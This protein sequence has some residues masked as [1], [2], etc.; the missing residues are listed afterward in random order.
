MISV[1]KDFYLKMIELTRRLYLRLKVLFSVPNLLGHDQLD[2]KNYVNDKSIIAIKG[3]KYYSMAESGFDRLQNGLL[4]QYYAITERFSRGSNSVENAVKVPLKFGMWLIALFVIFFGGWMVLAKI[5]GAAVAPG[6]I[7]FATSKQN[8]QHQIGGTIKNILVKE[9]DLVRRGQILLTMQDVDLRSEYNSLNN[10]LFALRVNEERLNAEKNHSVDFVL[11]DDLVALM[12]E[13]KEFVDIFKSQ[14]RL[15][16]ANSELYKTDLQILDAKQEQFKQNVLGLEIQR[17]AIADQIGFNQ[18]ELRAVEKLFAEGGVS[19]SRLLHL[20]TQNSQLL[21]SLGNVKSAIAREKQQIAEVQTQK[22]FKG[23]IRFKEIENE[24]KELSVA[25]VN[26]QEK[27]NSRRDMLEKTIVRS[28]MNGVVNNLHFHKSGEIVRPTE[29]LMEIVPNNDYLIVE[30]KLSNKDISE[31]LRAG[32]DLQTYNYQ[33]INHLFNA[34]ISLSSY[35]NRRY[36]KLKGSVFYVSADAITDPR[37]MG[38]SYYTIKIMISK[39]ELE[40]AAKANMKLFPGM[41]AMAFILT[42][43]RTPFSYFISPLTASFERAF[44]DS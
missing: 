18:E 36:G 12:E 16:M 30:A 39:K 2:E 9:G 23:N 25:I 17:D 11:S 41:P 3:R 31:L 37:Y 32:F 43:A 6:Q 7:S 15:F 38:Y 29:T 34:K 14:H 21:A 44:L 24:L 4:N 8:I 33:D 1:V 19:K 35:S 42:E 5:E 28:P 27:L 26:Y 20:K 40:N 10:Q 13:N 22:M